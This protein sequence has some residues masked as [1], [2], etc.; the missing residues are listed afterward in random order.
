MEP[1]Q[2]WA[3]GP[4][5]LALTSAACDRNLDRAS[6]KGA[7]PGDRLADDQ[8]LH[9]VGALIRIEG[10]GIREEARNVVIGDNAVTT[11]ELATP[12]DRLA[13]LRRAER[14]RKRRLV[15]A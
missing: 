10:F 9:L 12:G 7:D 3:T 5:T 6:H 2:H 8:I 1:T 4:L 14:L 13:R 15:V 11:Y